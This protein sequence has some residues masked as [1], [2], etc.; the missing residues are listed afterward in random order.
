MKM[1]FV[2]AG[3]PFTADY[4]SLVRLAGEARAAGHEVFVFCLAEGIY[5]LSQPEL[6]QITVAYC[7]HNAAQRGWKEGE[8]SRQRQSLPELAELI[9]RSDR[10][11]YFPGS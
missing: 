2:L 3:S 7:G 4:L 11:L 10:C 9:S 1:L 6:A 8:G 5:A